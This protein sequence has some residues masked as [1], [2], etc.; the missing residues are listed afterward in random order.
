MNRRRQDV[1]E[2]LSRHRHLSYLERDVTTVANDLR[3]D[4]DQPLA[5]AGSD[6]SSAALGTASVRMKL[7]RL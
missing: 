2:H 4:L 3:V 7:P 6:H 1:G 5:Q